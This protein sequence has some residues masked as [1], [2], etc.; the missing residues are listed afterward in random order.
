AAGGGR[1]RIDPV[2]RGRRRVRWGRPA[3]PGDAP[4]AADTGGAGAAGGPPAAVPVRGLPAPV[5]RGHP[6]RRP[7]PVGGA[8]G[9]VPDGDRSGGGAGGGAARAGSPTRS[10]SAVG[11]GRDRVGS[12]PPPPVPGGAEHGRPGGEPRCRGRPGRWAPR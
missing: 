10:A 9:R 1:A 4:V 7:S 5:L 12:V 3:R 8:R 2:G 11:R 6:G